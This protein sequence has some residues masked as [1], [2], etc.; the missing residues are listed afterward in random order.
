MTLGLTGASQKI[1]SLVAT[2]NQ[3]QFQTRTVNPVLV[4]SLHGTQQVVVTAGSGGE[5]GQMT[6]IPQT[7]QLLHQSSAVSGSHPDQ[8]S[9]VQQ[10]L[11]PQ[12]SQP[13]QV[14][15]QQMFQQQV[16]LQKPAGADQHLQPQ[17]GKDSWGSQETTLHVLVRVS[18]M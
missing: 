12:S 14:V 13:V 8:A 18:R 4:R 5:S 1:A 3:A 9:A 15:Q 11:V 17:S 2:A 6:I 10:A 16:I 7:V